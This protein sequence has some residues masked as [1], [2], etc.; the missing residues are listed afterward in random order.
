MA[1]TVQLLYAVPFSAVTVFGALLARHDYGLSPAGTQL[2][3]SAFFVASLL[4]RLAITRRSPVPAK[5]RV[6]LGAALVTAVGMVVLSLGGSP[7]VLFT[8]MVVLG[9]AHGVTFPLALALVAESVPS[10]QLAAANA[11][12]FAATNL[13]SV[14][15]PILLGQ[16]VEHAGYPAMCL[17]VLG[18]VAVFSAALA[19]QSAGAVPRSL[20]YFKNGH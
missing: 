4:G 15:A 14:T 19:A 12:L 17:A 2:A 6:L 8:A 13:V 5:H 7:L 20:A 9:V 3:F 10:E 11:S 16:I 18:P 1:L